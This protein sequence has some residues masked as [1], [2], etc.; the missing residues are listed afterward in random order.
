MNKKV[1]YGVILILIAI[2]TLLAIFYSRITNY[3]ERIRTDRENREALEAIVK[4]PIDSKKSESRMDAIQVLPDKA[5]INVPFVCQA[6]LHNQES[7]DYHHASC[8]EAAVLQALYHARGIDSIVPK[9]AHKI[10]LDMITWQEKNFGLHKDIH[11]DS[12]K[13]L[14]IGFFGLDSD[15]I[16]IKRKAALDDIRRFVAEGYPV[17]APTYGRTLKNPYYTPPGPE[18]HMVTVIGYTP[19]RIITNDVGTK[20]GKD[21]S[22]DNERFMKSMNQEGADILIIRLK[23]K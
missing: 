9:E 8:E 13:M 5:Y 11:A 22:Y 21:F 17:I 12:V 4:E 15:E 16:I 1:K 20:R 19:D 6:P 23:K 7:W 14:M 2:I 18:Y 10:F 3:C